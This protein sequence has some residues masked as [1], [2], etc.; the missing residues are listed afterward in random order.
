[1]PSFEHVSRRPAGFATGSKCVPSRQFV[2]RTR[3]R[4]RPQVTQPKDAVTMPIGGIGPASVG[5]F[6]V[7]MRP[8]RMHKHFRQ[9][10]FPQVDRV[11]AGNRRHRIFVPE[12][13]TCTIKMPA[14]NVGVPA[15][16]KQRLHQLTARWSWG[17]WRGH[18]IGIRRSCWMV[19]QM[20][21][22]RRTASIAIRDCR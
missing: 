17:R 8:R 18:R 14:R 15:S 12:G 21:S 16:S 10:T 7:L 6:G 19:S 20:N 3:G 22:F 13:E 5:L 1:M 11:V 2:E 4:T 9:A